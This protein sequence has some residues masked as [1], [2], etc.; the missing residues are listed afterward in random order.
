MRGSAAY[1]R[2]VGYV[3]ALGLTA[4]ITAALFVIRDILDTTLIALLLLIPVGVSTSTWGLGAGITAALSAFLEFNYLFIQPYHTFAVHRPGDLV[5]LLVFLIVAVVTSQLVG[6]AKAGVE[7]ATARER[8]TTQLYELSTGLAGLHDS[9]QITRILSEQLFMAFPCEHLEIT[10]SDPD[11]VAARLP[12]G[13]PRPSRPPELVVPMPAVRGVIGEIQSWR[14]LPVMSSAE[15][16]LVRTFASQG[17]LALERAALAQAESRARLLEE[18]DRFKSSLL[19]S[20]SHD[21]R[22]PLATIKAAA[23][24]LRSGEIGW[25]S[26]ARAELL[27]AIDDEAD[28]LNMLVGNLLDMSRIE[29]GALHPQRTWNVLAEI[30]QSVLARMRHLSE[31]HRLVIDIPED[32]PLV[33]VDFVLMGQVFT[34]LLSNSLRFAPPDTSVRVRA[35]ARDDATVLIEVSNQGPPVPT[36]HLQGIFDKFYRMTAA[37]RVTG[38]GLGLSIC[39]GVIEAHGGIIWAENRPDGF[40]FNFTLPL[41]MDGMPQPEL[42]AAHEAP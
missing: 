39:K 4:A 9:G 11:S 38:T 3:L 13:T 32:L 2:I 14:T 35:Q 40:A 27:A 20:V 8:E 36:E 6:R 21:L 24:S 42:P 1:N 26:P 28:H 15:K 16:R 29:S 22:T 12:P 30:V 19:S 5:I 31:G 7:A 23:S 34:N 18:S 10:L 33:P 25:E 41:R 37:D 17:A